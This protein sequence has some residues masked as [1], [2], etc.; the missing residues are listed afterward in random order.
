MKANSPIRFL[1]FL[2][3]FLLVF[4]N[5][6]KVEEVEEDY[7]V[8]YLGIY[9]CY[10]SIHEWNEAISLDTNYYENFTLEVKIDNS[11]TNNIYVNNDLV[12]IDETGNFYQFYFLNYHDYS[13]EFFAGD[14]VRY[15]IATGGNGGG[16]SKRY[17]GKKD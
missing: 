11:S 16:K 8:K 17:L 9:S 6:K 3:V 15:Y 12:P 10:G 13:I 4:E 1:P 7:R 2:I 14:S 5:C